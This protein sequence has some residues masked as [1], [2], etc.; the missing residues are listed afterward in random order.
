MNLKKLLRNTE[1]LKLRNYLLKE[2]K[3]KRDSKDD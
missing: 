2:K 3:N 1:D